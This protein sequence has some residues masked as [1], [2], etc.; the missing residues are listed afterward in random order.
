MPLVSLQFTY[1][2]A[3]HL[4]N[5]GKT[6]ADFWTAFTGLALWIPMQYVSVGLHNGNQMSESEAF[7][8]MSLLSG[9]LSLNYNS[10]LLGFATISGLY[11]YLGIFVHG[12][13]GGYI[14][15]FQGDVAV[16]NCVSASCIF[17]AFCCVCIIYLSL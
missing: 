8:M 1:S 10:K 13:F 11:S 7:P 5:L 17:N 6:N 14:I 16:R 9:L 2:H 15:G 3:S 12:F 4:C